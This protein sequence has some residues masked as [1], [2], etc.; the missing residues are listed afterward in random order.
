M[1]YKRGS[2]GQPSVV[3]VMVEGESYSERPEIMVYKG[4]SASEQTA[5]SLA[6]TGFVVKGRVNRWKARGYGVQG[7]VS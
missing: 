2:F 7:R 5:A 3:M 4:K 1:A 6:A